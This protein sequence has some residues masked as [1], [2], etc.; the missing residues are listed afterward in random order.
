MGRG[1]GTIRPALRAVVALALC[2]GAEVEAQSVVDVLVRQRQA[3]RVQE[4][5]AEIGPRIPARPGLLAEPSDAILRSYYAVQR[6]RAAVRDSLAAAD[7]AA[8]EARIRDARLATLRWRKVDPDDQGDFLDRF[9][10]TYW[11]AARPRAL[12]IDTVSTPVL[13]GRLQAAFGSPTRNADAQRRYGYG[14]S[15]YVQ[16][17][18]WFVV[19]DSIPL[20]ALDLD[21]PFGRGLLVAGDERYGAFLD[22]LKRDLSRRLLAVRSPDPW[23]DYYH[24]F[25]RGQW[26]RTGF[27]GADLFTRT[28]RTPRWSGRAPSDRW[29]IHR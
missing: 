18:Y 15:E 8:A 25:D 13:R 21:G 6:Q 28:V 19:N 1:A 17:E 14:G 26:Y 20:L 12:P 23:V 27:N 3:A 24:S 11:R 4:V 7:S 9:R 2:V 16:F 5:M 10:E 22:D 29:I